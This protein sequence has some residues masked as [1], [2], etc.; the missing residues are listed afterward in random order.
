M[1]DFAPSEAGLGRCCA[2]VSHHTCDNPDELFKTS[3]T[4]QNSYL[5]KDITPYND[6]LFYI[7]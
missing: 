3:W 4:L 5:Q 6:L 1:Y 2:A 7:I